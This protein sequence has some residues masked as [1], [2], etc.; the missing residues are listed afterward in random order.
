[1]GAT[2]NSG[3][4]KTGL[5][6]HVDAGNPKSYPGSGTT[7]YNIADK[8]YPNGTMYAGVTYAAGPPASMAFAG[9]ST[10]YVNFGTGAT[11]FS[12]T[13]ATWN[14]LHEF[15]LEAWAKSSGMG[16]GM[17]LSGIWGVTYGMRLH[18]GT[19]YVSFG[20][21]NG[22]TITGVSSNA[23]WQDGVWHHILGTHRNAGGELYIDG[24]LRATSTLRWQGKTRWS[25]NEANL[26]RDNNDI[27]YYMN[28]NIAIARFYR[29]WLSFSDVRRNFE[30]ERTRFGV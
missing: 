30:A 16:S 25:S 9:T 21:D 12:G 28:G 29:K 5:M 18:F 20:I 15:T 27:Y 8:R 23:N 6:V 19:N 7:W 24:V 4:M 13:T 17:T 14:N 11:Y 1:M 22:T 2:Y 26:G 10:S 3:I